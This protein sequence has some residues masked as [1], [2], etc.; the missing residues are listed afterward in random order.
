MRIGIIGDSGLIG[1]S[2]ALLCEKN[3]Y[4]V[5]VSDSN[6]DYIFNLNHKICLSNEPMIQSML[7][8]TIKFSATTDNLELIKNSDMIFTFVSTP[9]SITENLDTTNVF[10]IINNFYSASS[11]DIPIYNKK[12]IVGSVTNPGDVEQI[13]QRLEMF[14]VQVAYVPEFTSPGEIVK[15]FQ[16]SEVI[17]IGTEH[18]ELSNQLVALYTKIQ[19]T[20]LNVYTMSIKSAELTKLAISGLIATKITYGNMLGEVMVNLGL[21]NEI[22]VVLSALCGDSK[23]DKNHIKYGFG[24]GGQSLPKENRIFGNFINKLGT[25]INIPSKM[26]NFNRE[27]SIF[28]KNFFIKNNPDKLIPFVMNHLTYKKGVNVMEESQQFQLCIDLLNDGYM[29]HIIESDEI[30]KKLSPLSESYDNRLK[31]FKQGTN[32]QGYQIKL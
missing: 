6:E 22:G 31:F 14:N 17:L 29:L 19:T 25:E 1:L 18:Q 3:G 16:Q 23:S 9:S 15:N 30:T 26:D 27:H 5:I 21:E 32:P 10:E 7:F 8:D 28:L 12:F 20:Q 4:D 11:L 24:F 13:Q 2:F